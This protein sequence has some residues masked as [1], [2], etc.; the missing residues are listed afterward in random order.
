MD[1]IQLD[2]QSFA[3]SLTPLKLG[4]GREN[5][6]NYIRLLVKYAAQCCAGVSDRSLNKSPL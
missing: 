3:D 6:V 5:E 1:M 2:R 4:E